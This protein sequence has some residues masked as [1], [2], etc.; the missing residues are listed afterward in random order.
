MMKMKKREDISPLLGSLLMV[1]RGEN[2]TFISTF[3]FS[4]E[5][6]QRL[7]FMQGSVKFRLENRDL[8]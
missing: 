2:N 8:A 5:A 7:Y 1:G 6:S 4:N 3:T